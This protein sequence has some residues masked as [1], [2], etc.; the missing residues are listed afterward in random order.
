MQKNERNGQIM[1][2]MT[3]LQKIIFANLRS[4]V[5]KISIS[6]IENLIDKIDEEFKECEYFALDKS[7][8]ETTYYI[9]GSSKVRDKSK[10]PE[11][12]WQISFKFR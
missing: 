12:W 1:T 4:I 8:A 2:N 3:I 6:R 7:S 9:S 5:G 11:D 10:S